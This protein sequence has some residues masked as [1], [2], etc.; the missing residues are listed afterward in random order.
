MVAQRPSNKSLRLTAMD[1]TGKIKIF[2]VM[3]RPADMA[4]L[5]KELLE[6]IELRKISHPEECRAPAETKNG[7][8][9]VANHEEEAK[10]AEATAV[11]DNEDCTEPS[12]KKPVV[13]E[14]KN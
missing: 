12:P 2:L 3:G 4:L 7:I 1:N 6:R 8:G 14:G 13:N 5:H 11:P 9:S 10:E